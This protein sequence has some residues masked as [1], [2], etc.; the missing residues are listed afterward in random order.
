MYKNYTYLFKSTLI[1]IILSL[2]VNMS[3]RCNFANGYFIS[4]FIVCGLFSLL[5]RKH[6]IINRWTQIINRLCIELNIISAVLRFLVMT[7]IITAL[8]LIISKSPA[9]FQLYYN[10]NY[11]YNYNI[12]LKYFRIIILSCIWYF[13]LM[14]ISFSLLISL[15]FCTLTLF[16]SFCYAFLINFT[17]W[18]NFIKKITTFFIIVSF[19]L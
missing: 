11:Y 19:F 12:N 14:N 17:K 8:H 5:I 16:I 7:T 9:L 4:H 13:I 1:F 18:F 10:Y 15:G 2:F 3:V 6:T